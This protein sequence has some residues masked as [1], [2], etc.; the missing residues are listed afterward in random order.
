MA[1]SKTSKAPQRVIKSFTPKDKNETLGQLIDRKAAHGWT[2]MVFRPDEKDK[3]LRVTF[4]KSVAQTDNVDCPLFVL[5]ELSNV[6]CR[7]VLAMKPAQY[8]QVES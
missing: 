7:A 2:Y 3:N 8:F 6:L 1:K 5:T 4:Y